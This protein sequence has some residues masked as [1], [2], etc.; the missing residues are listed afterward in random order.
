ML[1]VSSLWCY[2]AITWAILGC[3]FAF[4]LVILLVRF[5]VLPH[6]GDYRE[7]IAKQLSEATRQKVTIGKL[8]GRWSGLNLQLTLGDVLVYDS[9]NRPALTLQRVDSTL[10]WWSLVLGEPRFDSIEIR[11]PQLD[12][13]RDARG[14]FSVAGIELNANTDGGGISDWL[15]RQNEISIRD[16]S[17]TWNDELRAAP[18]LAL[19]H[20]DF[21]FENDVGMNENTVNVLRHRYR[22]D[23]DLRERLGTANTRDRKS[24]DQ[25]RRDVIGMIRAA[26]L[27]FADEGVSQQLRSR[28]LLVEAFVGCNDRRHGRRCGSTHAG[29]EGDSLLDRNTETKIE[30]PLVFQT[31]EPCRRGI[32]RRIFRN[33]SHDA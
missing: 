33:L 5:W 23:V 1:H 9:A 27:R 6:M 30:F 12:V 10:S 7:P 8:D 2:R 17:I 28:E 31:H 4:A 20:V 11:R 15:L 13:R 21:R 32:L 26:C 3:A 14:V 29:T 24:A 18:Q 25:T 16:A 22:N 19:E